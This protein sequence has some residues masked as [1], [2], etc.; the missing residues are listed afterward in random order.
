M[1]MPLDGCTSRDCPIFYQRKK[2]QL[3]LD[4]MQQKLAEMDPAF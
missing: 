3:D 1:T 2:V 4:A